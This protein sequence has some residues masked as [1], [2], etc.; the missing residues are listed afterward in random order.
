MYWRIT[1][2]LNGTSA[3]KKIASKRVFNEEKK[4]YRSK[5]EIIVSMNPRSIVIKNIEK[6]SWYNMLISACFNVMFFSWNCCF[7]FIERNLSNFQRQKF[8][9]F[10]D[11]VIIVPRIHKVLTLW[12]VGILRLFFLFFNV[13]WR[14]ISST[15]TSCFF[16]CFIFFSA[17]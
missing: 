14:N 13:A 16:Y 15:A 17:R 5:D 9:Y 2:I 6:Y 8:E 1:H 11:F 3:G 12:G 10:E 4:R 7:V